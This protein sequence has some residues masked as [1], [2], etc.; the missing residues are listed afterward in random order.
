M[1]DNQLPAPKTPSPE[2]FP[3]ATSGFRPHERVESIRRKTPGSRERYGRACR[4]L[5]GG[6]SSGMRRTA[7]P[8]PLY[9]HRGCGCH[10]TDV[11]GNTYVDLVNALGPIV[12]GYAYPAVPQAVAAPPPRGPRPGDPRQQCRRHRQRPLHPHHA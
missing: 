5:A 2:S 10:L 11:D 7:R 9:F 6:V 4:S 1:T 3:P 8:H 12:L